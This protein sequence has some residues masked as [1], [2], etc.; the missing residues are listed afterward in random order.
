MNDRNHTTRSD[1]RNHYG[2]LA[3]QLDSCSGTGCCAS[4]AEAPVALREAARLLGYSEA[5]VDAL[6]AN[7]TMTLGCGN[8]VAVAALKPGETVLDLGS[9]AGFDSMLAADRVGPTGRVIGVDMTPAM[10]DKA[11]TAAR[12]RPH[13]EFRLGEIE[14]LPVADGEVDVIMSNCVINLSPQ[15]DRVF[16]EAYRVLRSGGRLS[17]SDTVRLKALEGTPWEG[18]EHISACIAGSVA[19]SELEDLLASAGFIDV[20]VVLKEGLADAIATWAPGR[21]LEAYI[22]SALIEARKP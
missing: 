12:D 18:E 4:G 19:V 8:P 14:H 2:Q 10:L 15:K 17:I 1:V 13:V 22:G 16:A 9:G 20:R 3:Q 21:G 11:R 7:E 5:D 6:P